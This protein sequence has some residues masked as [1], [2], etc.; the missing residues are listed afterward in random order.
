MISLE[1]NVNTVLHVSPQDCYSSV[2]P[3]HAAVDCCCCSDLLLDE[4]NQQ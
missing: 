1:E 4:Y 3:F 2:Q